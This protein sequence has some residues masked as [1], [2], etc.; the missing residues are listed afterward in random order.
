M[1]AHVTDMMAQMT[2][3]E[4][5]KEKTIMDPACGSGRMLLSAAKVSRQSERAKHFFSPSET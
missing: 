2:V 1:A 5:A 3:G 4:E